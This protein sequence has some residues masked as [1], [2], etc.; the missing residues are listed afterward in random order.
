MVFRSLLHSIS[1]RQS[2]LL[3]IVLAWLS[4]ELL[5]LSGQPRQRPTTIQFSLATTQISQSVSK[6]RLWVDS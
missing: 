2:R 1:S 4:Q 5:F 3:A 6:N